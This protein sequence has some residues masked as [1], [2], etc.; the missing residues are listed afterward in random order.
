MK[1]SDIIQEA[2]LL[3][4]A[5]AHSLPTTYV[6]SDLKNQDAYLQYRFGVALAAAKAH[7]AGNIEYEPESTFGENMIIVAKSSEEEEIVNLALKLIGKHNSSKIVSTRQSEEQPDVN[8]TSIAIQ[9]ELPRPKGR[10]FHL[11]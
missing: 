11:Q 6:L 2:S 3:P 10:G 4:S 8:K 7:Q 9:C 5:V 1:V